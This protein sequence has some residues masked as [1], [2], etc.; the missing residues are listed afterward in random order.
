MDD[1]IKTIDATL[2][3][4]ELV[5]LRILSMM[6]ETGLSGNQI[7]NAVLYADRLI[8]ECAD[9]EGEN[10]LIAAHNELEIIEAGET[11]I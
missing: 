2:T 5:A 6:A 11:R 4:L 3:K 9:K 8:R 1:S 7:S 10:A